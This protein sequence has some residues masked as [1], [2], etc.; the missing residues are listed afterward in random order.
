MALVT[1]AEER[2]VLGM[3]SGCRVNPPRPGGGP[4]PSPSPGPKVTEPLEGEA[5]VLSSSIDAK[6]STLRVSRPSGGR[7]PPRPRPCA[8]GAG[9]GAAARAPEPTTPGAGAA[10]TKAPTGGARSGGPMDM[11]PVVVGGMEGSSSSSNTRALWL[12]GRWCTC[13]CGVKGRGERD[14]KGLA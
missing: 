9:N 14:V 1:M 8:P 3:G 4:S 11:A 13:D 12:I 10:T 6:L 7:G 5:I 2:L